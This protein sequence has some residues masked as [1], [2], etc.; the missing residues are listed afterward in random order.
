MRGLENNRRNVWLTVAAHN[1]GLILRQMLGSGKPREFAG[2]CGQLLSL[3]LALQLATS[4]LYR[5]VIAPCS[6][7]RLRRCCNHFPLNVTT[8]V[9]STSESRFFNGLLA[10]CMYFRLRGDGMWWAVGVD[11]IAVTFVAFLL[12]LRLHTRSAQ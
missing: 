7:N 1:L 6:I 8:A 11:A 2:L 12:G 10:T 3:Y 9:I 5:S 4:R